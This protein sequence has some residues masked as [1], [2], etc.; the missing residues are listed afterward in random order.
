MALTESV[1]E[2][3]M[4]GETIFAYYRSVI[5]TSDRISGILSLTAVYKDYRLPTIQNILREEHITLR[6]LLMRAEDP[7]VELV[8]ASGYMFAHSVV[9]GEDVLEA[10][11]YIMAFKSMTRT[12]LAAV[13]RREIT[14]VSRTLNHKDEM[15]MS[16]RDVCVYAIA[17]DIAASTLIA[18]A[19]M[20]K[21]RRVYGTKHF[22]RAEESGQLLNLLL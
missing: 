12:A 17:L 4:E 14:S 18:V 1:C 5:L 7:T 3:L 21:K 6:N 19:E 20:M 16:V 13:L 2:S 11:I 8:P 15:R 9:S 22:R 10:I